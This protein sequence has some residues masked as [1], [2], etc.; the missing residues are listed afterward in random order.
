MA[1]VVDVLVVG[2]GPAGRAAAAACSDAGLRTGVIDPA[3]RRGWPQTYAAW[4]DEL[5]ALPGDALAATA[6]QVL[7]RGTGW[8]GWHRTYA[9][10]DNTRLWQHLWRADVTEITGR[11]VGVEHGPTGST[12]V[13]RDG[14]RLA[15]AVVVDAS[16]SSRALLGGR[17]ART[18]AEQT[19]VGAVLDARD[20]GELCPAGSAVFMD[21][22]Q[23]PHTRG[24]WPS[25]RYTVPLGGGRVLVEETSLVRRPGLPLAQLRRRLTDRLAEHGALPDARLREERVRFP[26]DDPLPAAG[27]VIAFGAAGGFVHPATGFSVAASLRSAPWLAAAISAGLAGGPSAAVRAARQ[28]LWPPRALSG[29]LLHRRALHALLGLPGAEVPEFFELFFGLPRRHREGF[30]SWP[31]DPRVTAAAMSALFARA[32]WRLRRR[33]A[34][35]TALP[36]ARPADRGLGGH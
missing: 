36:R 3:P 20:A 16:G 27:R 21:W 8:H 29:R 28:V 1:G 32:P 31:G 33:L 14:R 30:L 25:F 24:G 23:A 17:P 35:G 34:A 26:V 11:A 13:L 18:A 19:A 12:V 10:L 22:Q 9:V 5:P 7:V 4:R 15:A 6:P 2:S